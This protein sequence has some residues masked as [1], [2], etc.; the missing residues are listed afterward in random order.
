MRKRMIHSI[1]S[2]VLCVNL[3]VPSVVSAAETEGQVEIDVQEE[4]KE[5][6]QDYGIGTESWQI[7]NGRWWYQ[8]GDGS[9]P[10]SQLKK[11]DGSWYCFDGAGWMVTGWYQLKNKWHYFYESGAIASSTW[12]GDYYILSNGDMAVSQWIGEYYVGSDGKWIP[13]KQ[14]VTE[15]WQQTN[16]RWWYQNADGSYPVSQLKLING[17]WYCFD[18]AGWM[19][20]GWYKLGSD[21][22]YLQGSGAMA[23]ATWIGDYYVQSN[24]K[25]AVNQ[26][27]GDYYVGTDGK[28]IPDYKE[29]NTTGKVYSKPQNAQDLEK[30]GDWQL[31]GGRW[32]FKFTDGT[33]PAGGWIKIKDDCYYFDKEGW[34]LEDQW[35]DDYYVNSAGKWNY[36]RVK[37]SNGKTYTCEKQ[38]ITDPQ[39]SDLEFWTAIVYA[40]AGDQGLA[41]MSAVTMSILNRMHSK[42]YPNDLRTVVYQRSQYQPARTG[43]LTR[44]LKNGNAAIASTYRNNTRVAVQ[45]ALNTYQKY[46]AGTGT[47]QI[48]GITLPEGQEF[49]YCYFMTPAA[50][51]GL[52]LDEAGCDALYVPKQGDANLDHG[53]VFFRKWVQQS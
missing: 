5:Q 40:E 45:N 33:Y 22:Y 35:I 39:V 24:G 43:T 16:G 47:R 6:E 53:H 9:Y 3:L 34:M 41:G 30:K 20:T 49:D 2:L 4:Q 51:R 21:W 8:N 14:K 31:T 13:G 46:L 27:I 42:S 50:F 37:D 23:S 10:T 52:N 7:T 11:I 1:L 32:W 28:W 36:V 25:M 19:V 18:A 29:N 17:S 48:A 38:Y 26:W 15:G 12:I 44:F